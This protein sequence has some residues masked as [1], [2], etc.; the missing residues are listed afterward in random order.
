[1][2]RLGPGVQNPGVQGYG[3]QQ[4][5]GLVE[6]KGLVENTGSGGKHEVSRWKT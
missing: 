3:V 1:M 2:R 5:W 4:T 6:K